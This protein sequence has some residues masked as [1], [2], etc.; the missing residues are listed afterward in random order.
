MKVIL[1]KGLT[2]LVALV[3][4]LAGCRKDDDQYFNSIIG[5]WEWLYTTGGIII[6]YPRAGIKSVTEFTKDGWLIRT[7]NDSIIFETRYSVSA[8]TLKYYNGTE[9]FYKIEIRSDTLGL[10]F[11]KVGFNDYYKK[12]Y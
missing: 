7:R 9:L 11:I 10:I 4:V 1:I 3:I 2:F 6:Q 5:K 8:D 12:V